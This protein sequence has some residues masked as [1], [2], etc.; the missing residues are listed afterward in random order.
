M[1]DL[2]TTYLG[3]P[4]KNPLVPSSSPLCKHL[5]S[6]LQ[7][8]DAGAAAIVLHSFYEEELIAEDAMADR[9]L[10]HAELHDGESAGFLPDHGSYE[11]AIDRYLEHLRRVKARV[12]IPVIASLNGVTPSGWVDLGREL[13]AA[14]ADALELNVYH[15]AADPN[16]TGD[17]VEARYLALL[18]ELKRTVA[19][20]VV[21]KLPPFF[22]SLPN[23]VRRLEAGGAAGVS[24]F[25]R[26][27]QPDIDLD[28]LEMVDR[29]ELSSPDE[30]LLRIR[31]IAILRAQTRITLAAT[32]GVYGYQEA[33]KLLL[34]GADV[35]HLASCLLEHG[36]ARLT[37]ILH[38]LRAW[39]AD[40]EYESVAQLK[41]SMCQANLRDAS[42]LARQSYIRVLDSFTPRPGV[43]R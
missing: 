36:P 2:S 30:A 13:E 16:E 38:D 14:G 27:F 1:I 31:W 15:I 18:T 26:F 10:L 12:G 3:L 39:M 7:L 25:N 17:A 6:V 23:F 11:S 40:R 35:V 9:F 42:S 43:W 5:D 20:P 8:E 28:S 22:A 37:Q 34:A 19:V 21:M 24:L 29:L 33:L 4:L 32:G 41:G